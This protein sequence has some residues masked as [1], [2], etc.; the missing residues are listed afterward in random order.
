M[1]QLMQIYSISEAKDKLDEIVKYSSNQPA[2]LVARDHKAV[3]LSEE[4]YS[5][6]IETLHLTSIPG[7][8]E[9]I[10]ESGMDEFST[11]ELDWGDDAQSS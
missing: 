3:I 7:F 8:K 5:G 6:L 4:Y 11:A 1:E 10:M 2:Y 9:S